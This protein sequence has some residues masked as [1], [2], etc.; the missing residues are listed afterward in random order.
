M[1]WQS[2]HLVFAD[3]PDLDAA[4]KAVAQGIFFNQ[5]EVCTAGSRLLVHARSV[6]T[7]CTR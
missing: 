5:G 1:R 3:A 7:S 4:A 2:P 6:R